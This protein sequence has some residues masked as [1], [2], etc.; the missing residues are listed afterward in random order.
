MAG[1]EENFLHLGADLEADLV[2]KFRSQARK[3]KFKQIEIFRRFLQWWTSLD[4]TLQRQFYYAEPDFA[5]ELAAAQDEAAAARDAEERR[6]K[7]GPRKHA[8][9][10]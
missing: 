6:R 7:H 2:S 8:K 4:P 9:S 5:S 3:G 10:G 1:S